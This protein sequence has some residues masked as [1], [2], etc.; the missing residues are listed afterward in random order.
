MLGNPKEENAS[1]LPVTLRNCL[2]EICCAM[3][4]II[5]CV[6]IWNFSYINAIWGKR[7]KMRRILPG[8]CK[9]SVATLFQK[10]GLDRLISRGTY[11][12]FGILNR[13]KSLI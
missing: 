5:K 9:K 3:T 7:F 11:I 10:Y 6:K 4:Q 13:E 1:A 8:N 2:R 12:K